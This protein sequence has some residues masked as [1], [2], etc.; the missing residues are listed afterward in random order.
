LNQR[1]S[2]LSAITG[3]AQLTQISLPSTKLQGDHIIKA[4]RE[5]A[6]PQIGRQKD[7]RSANW[8]AKRLSSLASSRRSSTDVDHPG[9]LSRQLIKEKAIIAGSY[10]NKSVAEQNSVDIPSVA[11]FTRLKPALLE[12]PFL[13]KD[14]VIIIRNM[15]KTCNRQSPR[16][17][18][19][20][21]APFWSSR[22]TPGW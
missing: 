11:A 4:W 10:K 15:D 9:V 21:A 13:S 7:G 5:T 22:G 12:R 2:S 14:Q 1:L 20:E 17:F 16:A 8:S 19:T 6:V 3:N 18:Q